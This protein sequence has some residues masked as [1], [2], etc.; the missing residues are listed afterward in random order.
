MRIRNFTGCMSGKKHWGVNT[1]GAM[2]LIVAALFSEYARGKNGRMIYAGT[3]EAHMIQ[4]R[5]EKAEKRQNLLLKSSSVFNRDL[6]LFA[7][8]EESNF[9]FLG[10]TGFIS[11]DLRPGHYVPGRYGK[12][13]FFEKEGENQ[14]PK[15]IANV[16]KDTSGFEHSKNVVIKSMGKFFKFGK[17]VL[18]IKLPAGGTVQTIPVKGAFA[19]PHSGKKWRLVASCYVRG[20]KGAKITIKLAPDL[21]ASKESL[22]I[23]EKT[24]NK[25]SGSKNAK[26]E[27]MLPDKIVPQN[28]VLSGKW[29][30]VACFSFFDSKKR[31]VPLA[32]SITSKENS[33]MLLLADGFQLEETLIHPCYNGLP[34]SWLPGKTR[35][36]PHPLRINANLLGSFP[37]DEGSIALWTK[38]PNNSNLSGPNYGPCL[39]FGREKKWLNSWL[40]GPQFMAGAD[41]LPVNIGAKM[42]NKWIHI[43]MTWNKRIISVYAN[44]E[45]IKSIDCKRKNRVATPGSILMIGGGIQLDQSANAI[46]DDVSL[47]KRKLSDEE[48]RLL[49]GKKITRKVT[50]VLFF[51]PIGRSV[52]YRNESKVS[53][54]FRIRS[55]KPK[56]TP[57]VNV[58][59]CI[60]DVIYSHQLIKMSKG[61]AT[62]H[63]EFSP[64]QLK[65]GRYI[66]RLVASC[67]KTASSYIE[68]PVDI[69]PELYPDNYI[70]SAWDGHSDSSEWL[71]FYKKIG[72]NTV[73]TKIPFAELLGK[74]GFLYGW[75]S[76][77]AFFS[78]GILNTNPNSKSFFNKKV[79][80]SDIYS[81]AKLRAPYPNW[82]FVLVNSEKGF[83]AMQ[84]TEIRNK[85]FDAFAKKSLGFA[86]P[87]DKNLG[88]NHPMFFKFP[89]NQKPGKNGM[90]KNSHELKFL[91][92]WLANASPMYRLNAEMAK[93]IRKVRPDVKVWTDPIGFFSQ[94]SG[95]D[96]GS[97]WS[98]KIN[99]ESIIGDFESAYALVRGSGK[100]FY[101]T[102]GMWY[103]LTPCFNADV[104]LS[105]LKKILT[106]EQFKE[107]CIKQ[108]KA[109]NPNK[110]NVSKLPSSGTVKMDLAPTGDDMIQQAW[111]AVAY[112][113][114]DGLNYWFMEGLFHG[115]RRNPKVKGG[116]YFAE[117]GSDKRLGKVLKND[118]MPLG[119][120]LKGVKNAQRPIALLLPESS[121]WALTGEDG[122]MWWWGTEHYPNQWKEWLAGI[123]VPYDIV[124]DHNITTGSL[125]KYK[126]V[127]FPAAKYVESNVYKELV[128]AGQK[129]TKIILDSYGQQEYPNMIRWNQKYLYRP[130]LSDL[131]RKEYDQATLGP[132][133]SLKKSLLP[134]LNAYAVGEE[135]PVLLNVREYNGVKYVVVINNN[136]QSGAYTRWT[137]I[138]LFKPY[139]KAQ[140]VKLYLKASKNSAVY[141]FIKSKRLPAKESG[142][143]LVVDITLPPHSGRLVCVYPKAFKKIRITLPKKLRV[144]T[145]ATIKIVLL[146]T[147]GTLIKG[148]QL[149]KIRVLDPAGKEHDETGIYRLEDGKVDFAFRPALNEPAGQ[150]R[151]EVIERT[152]ALKASLL[153]EVK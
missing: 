72:I 15:N 131:A 18:S 74:S 97:N 35:R 142:S 26:I 39:S 86:I 48:I 28:I 61:V 112:I 19:L 32:F 3:S 14:F 10:N 117:P 70:L 84:G 146:D 44:G 4:A 128:F 16:E 79:V 41:K 133:E 8:F 92:W 33:Q 118:L 59:F 126:A 102:L 100:E 116:T 153:F 83:G 63:F 34:T 104:P 111:I 36:L 38:T 136:R 140:K 137:N 52:F 134:E 2:L 11:A 108:N 143:Y 7:D 54:D 124:K 40:V 151:I 138:S 98:Y 99:S 53:F 30:R 17:N 5:I 49:A 129:G 50:N 139:G 1:L 105:D 58:D 65:S 47:F 113:P 88:L 55:L 43:A 75:H 60:G 57:M 96:A 145:S 29:Q 121:L 73:D 20:S 78:R 141:E 94:T 13:F 149:V 22:I 12:G 120:M 9:V 115:I 24:N 6:I 95:L 21:T 66:I 62:V 68:I 135:G 82:K 132:L 51:Q 87:A 152:S 110:K 125:A 101:C 46:M 81:E 77:Y 148:R 23:N 90:Y 147:S 130:R 42:G 56:D 37:L 144:G 76:D 123:G 89:D 107:I 119:T 64:S 109:K 80:Y 150:W 71:A 114:S 67:D 122:G 45:L 127:I 85:W 103:Y 25:K 91:K 69:V 31:N 106:K 93:I 27:K